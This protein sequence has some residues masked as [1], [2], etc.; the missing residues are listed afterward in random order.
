MGQISKIWARQI[1][2]SRG[3]P[4]VEAACQLNTGEIS[5]SSVPAGTSTG[6]YESIELRDN[7]KTKYLGLGVEKAVKKLTAHGFQVYTHQRL[8][9]NDGGISLGQLF[10]VAKNY[11]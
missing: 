10:A 4:T 6:T 5:V 9:P 11:T 3:I 8:P 2:D 1:L 7:D